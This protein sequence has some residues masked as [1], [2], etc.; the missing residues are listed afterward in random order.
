MSRRCR[1]IRT[2]VID[3]PPMRRVIPGEP[4][5]S[6][7]VWARRGKGIQGKGENLD[8]VFPHTRE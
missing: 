7:S 1:R 2:L 8:D 3:T 6:D 5:H 4:V